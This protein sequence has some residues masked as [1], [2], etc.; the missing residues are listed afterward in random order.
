MILA[1]A[2]EVVRKEGLAGL[3][4]R[5]LAGRVGI[6]APSL[7]SYFAS[8]LDIYDAMF[9]QAYEELESRMR[10][11]LHAEEMDRDSFRAGSRTFFDFC[12]EDPERYQLLFQRT[13]PGFE[14]SPESYAASEGIPGEARCGAL[15]SGSDRA[16]RRRSVDGDQCRVDESA[17]RQRSRRR[18]VEPVARRRHRH[19]PRPHRQSRTEGRT[20]VTATATEVR[21]IPPITHD[22]AYPLAKEAYSRFARALTEVGDGQWSDPTD[23]TEWTVR[24]M[25]GHMLGAMRSAASFREFV[26]QQIEIGRRAR[27]DDR[28]TVDHMTALQIELTADLSP[29]QLVA[30]TAALVEQAARGRHRIPAPL[31]R[32][33]SF[34]V[35][36]G[37]ISERWTLGYLVDVILT[38][39]TFM[40]RIDL[41]RAIGAE[42]VVDHEPR[43]PHRGR[44]G[45]G[46]GPATRTSLHPPPVG[47]GRGDL[48][49][50][51]RRRTDPRGR[52]RV[53]PD[54]VGSGC[55]RRPVVH[56]RPLLRTRT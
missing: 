20:P 30:E 45:G 6:K 9:R 56:P 38:R 21:E 41:A 4:M 42:L 22:E 24:D 43:G 8:K 28:P 36:M 44:R 5:D 17:D 1:A 18:A 52:P 53:L 7:Y 48:P 25:A 3:T 32:W 16:R 40:H 26:R 37:E 15:R 33:A 49:G 34:P 11:F 35:V 2:W 29:D 23:C 55:G 14:P 54:R 39:D 12:T 10:P 27:Q 31:R 46:V 51:R 47:P 19:V 50:R 13:L